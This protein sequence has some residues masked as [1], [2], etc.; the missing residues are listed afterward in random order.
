MDKRQLKYAIDLYIK[1]NKQVVSVCAHNKKKFKKI[2]LMD[3][4]I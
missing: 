3:L 2:K 1:N 4:C